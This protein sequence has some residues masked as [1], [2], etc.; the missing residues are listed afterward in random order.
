MKTLWLIPLLFLGCRVPETEWKMVT[1]LEVRQT[2]R[3][4]GVMG[5]HFTPDESYILWAVAVH[6]YALKKWRLKE[7]WGKWTEV[8]GDRIWDGWSTGQ[9]IVRV[10]IQ[11]VFQTVLWPATSIW[12]LVQRVRGKQIS[13]RY[14]S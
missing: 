3:E 6:L 10:G 13:L 1:A 12:T 7:T 4:Q 2:L 11:V 5:Q 14:F 9:T 8:Y